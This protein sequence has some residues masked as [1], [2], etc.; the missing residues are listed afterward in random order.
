MSEHEQ[1][2]GKF[3]EQMNVIAEVLDE[4]FNGDGPKQ[5]GF[6]LLTYEFDGP[7]DG[8]VNYIGNGKREDV[9]KA[10]KE[11]IGRWEAVP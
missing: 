11:L 4:T 5:V 7:K 3:R 1:I 9:L 6:A 2:Q 10:L 8:R